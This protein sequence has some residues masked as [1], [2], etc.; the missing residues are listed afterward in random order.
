MHIRC[1][2]EHS[3]RHTVLTDQSRLE[4]DGVRLRGVSASIYVGPWTVMTET[5]M[6]FFDL[7]HITSTELRR[8]YS[9]VANVF[10]GGSSWLSVRLNCL[11]AG[12]QH[13][14]AAAKHCNKLIKRRSC[15]KLV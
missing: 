15:S 9:V 3:D 11:R 6:R 4:F 12:L 14:W 13:G 2:D 10:D 1:G 8:K 7:T 5:L